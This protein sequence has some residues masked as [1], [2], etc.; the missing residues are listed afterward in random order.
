MVPN[1]DLFMIMDIV[2]GYCSGQSDYG[3]VDMRYGQFDWIQTDWCC[4]QIS[5][6]FEDL[7]YTCA[8]TFTY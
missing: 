2:M 5:Q 7:C 4:G 8:V 3:H 6:M 1:M